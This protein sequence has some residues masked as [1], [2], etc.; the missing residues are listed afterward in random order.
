[1]YFDML[2]RL[3]MTHDRDRRTDTAIAKAAL[4]YVTSNSSRDAGCIHGT[5]HVAS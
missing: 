1:M 4:H 2:N 3:G 5:Q